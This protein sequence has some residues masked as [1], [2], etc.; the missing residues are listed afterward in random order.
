MR[1]SGIL[2]AAML[3]VAPIFSAQ[4]A[5]YDLDI[6]HSDIGF[7][8]T[9]MMV[10]QTK[11]RFGKAT[12]VL[13]LDEKDVT[14]S[15]IDVEINTLTIDTNNDDRD[16]HLRSPDFFDAEKY[17]KITFKSKEV[18]KK[19]KGYS[20][21]GDLSMHGVT[22]EVTLDVSKL[23]SAVKDPWG[24]ERVG[25]SASTVVNRKDFGLTWNK[26]LEAGGVA[27]GDDVTIT[28]DVEFVKRKQ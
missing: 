9:H 1:V 22:K 15:K 19:G 18:K 5:T 4:A 27:V 2:A 14:K 28:L 13:E 12:G 10:S 17:P 23:T 25:A 16:N 20:V 11:G 21:V 24:N 26:T 8:V 3:F 7:S 6:A